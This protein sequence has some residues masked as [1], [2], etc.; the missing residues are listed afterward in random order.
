MGSFNFWRKWLVGV[1]ICVAVFGMVLA[2]FPH[3]RVMDILFNN[4]I[5]P[6]FWEGGRLPSEVLAFQAWIYGVLGATISGWG[7]FM[8]F[9]AQYP[10]RAR[11]GWA[12]NCFAVAAAAWFVLDTALSALHGVF[13]N[14]GFN[15]IL[16][17]LIAI[18][19]TCTRRHFVS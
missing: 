5:D 18:P 12:W 15:T 4:Q 16:L 19:L 2:L 3:S 7:I 13:F 14:V 10:F 8:I 17:L 11:E 6:V 1:G 9:V